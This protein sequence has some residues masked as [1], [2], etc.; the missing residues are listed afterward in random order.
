MFYESTYSC[1]TWAQLFGGWILA[2]FL[3][4]IVAVYY[5]L[6]KR[7]TAK[8]FSLSR[9]LSRFKDRKR[10]KSGRFEKKTGG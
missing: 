2:G 1:V 5:W 7:L 10:G 9:Q 8:V 3:G 6:L 4:F